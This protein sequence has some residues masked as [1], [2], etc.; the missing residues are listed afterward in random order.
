LIFLGRGR[1]FSLRRDRVSLKEETPLPR[2]VKH[3]RD[4]E[5]TQHFHGWEER[6]VVSR[7]NEK[8]RLPRRGK[9][10]PRYAH[11]DLEERREEVR[12]K[13]APVTR[14]ETPLKHVQREH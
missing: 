3:R 13:E 2:A 12:R 4:R 14:K 5:S 10:T 7:Q 8:S 1:S 6:D 9:R 11:P